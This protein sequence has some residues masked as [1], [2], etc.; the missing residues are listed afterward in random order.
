MYRVMATISVCDRR[1]LAAAREGTL[2][3][4]LY[5]VRGLEG[6]CAAV[7]TSLA[8]DDYLVS[9]YRNL[10]DAI[11]KGASLRKVMAEQ[12]GRATGTSRGKGGPMHIADPDAGLMLTSGIVGGGLP[13]AVGLALAR[14]LDGTGRVTAVTFG[15]GATSIGAFHESMNLAA[16]WRLPLIFVCQNNQWGEHTALSEYAGNTDL[17]ARAESYGMNAYRVDGFDPVAVLDAMTAALKSARAGEGPAFLEC[18]TYRLSPHAATSD[19]SY[20]PKDDLA[21]ALL[22]DPTPSFRRRLLESGVSE[23]HLDEIDREAE[24]SVDD[25]FEFAIGSPLPDIASVIEDIFAP[26]AAPYLVTGGATHA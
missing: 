11:A 17:A 5:P 19:S 10:G 18:I 7:G 9:T 12:Y 22:R 23:F 3:A 21:A 24:Q 25:A 4:A 13:V 16:L 20:M 15:D 2:R 6:V 8:P 1:A 26:G 14:K